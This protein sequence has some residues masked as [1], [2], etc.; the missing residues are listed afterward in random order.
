MPTA[1]KY[2]DTP[3]STTPI[4]SS[5][6]YEY[7]VDTSRVV[8]PWRT[9]RT[10]PHTPP[11]L[12]ITRP[13]LRPALAPGYYFLS[14]AD[15]NKH[16]GTFATSGTGFI[17]DSNGDLIYAGLEDGMGFCSEWVAGMTD[18]RAQ[19][20]D[21]KRHITYWNGCNTRGHHWG[22][23]WG[24]V[25]FIDEEYRKFTLNPDLGIN[26]FEP[27]TRGNIDV[28][29]HEM[30]ERGTMLV[31]SYNNTQLDLRHIGGPEDAWVADSMFFEIDV[32]TQEVLFEWR[33]LGNLDFA[34]TH[35][36]FH[37]AGAGTTKKVPWDWVHIN[38]V[39]RVGEDYLISTRHHFAIYLISGK[40]GSVIWKLDGLDGGDF[41]SIPAQFRW[42]HHARAHN[43]TEHGM[44]VSV[45]N[46]MVNGP[47]N[48]DTQTTGL[49][50]WLPLPPNKN[51]PP[52][53][54]RNLRSPDEM[55]FT[56]TQG[57]YQ[58]DLGNGNGLIGY[59]TV[60]IIRE[61]D[62]SGSILWQAQ[63]GEMNAVM[64]YRGFKMEWTGTPRDWDPVVLIENPRLH[65]P[66]VYVSWNGA[67]GV[68]G[69]AVFAGKTSEEM[70]AVGA[71]EKRGFETVF[72]LEGKGVECVQLGAV[73]DGEIIRMSNIACLSDT[74]D[75]ITSDSASPANIH[76]TA[77]LQNE[78]SRL[79]AELAA[80][81]SET[82]TAYA[83][84]AK[85]ALGVVGLVFAAWGFVLLRDWRA[86]RRAAYAP[87]KREEW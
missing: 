22:H 11:V 10:S 52:V 49:A 16:D 24:R 35:Y 36:G 68:E 44:T 69:W 26:T 74:L 40:D 46:N 38:S 30:T 60:P 63:F 2:D 14:P 39:Q 75:P 64:N 43:V 62:S 15:S 81:Q 72:D 79:H 5:A 45:F 8:W 41:G 3:Y 65:T 83:L 37:A 77:A 7:T 66:R 54:V 58:M 55:L 78:I 87:V 47:H 34:A 27:A 73:R 4:P 32:R 20:L 84:F 85:V 80:A 42:Q 18:W 67:T 31:T 86:R 23:R 61:F 25:T 70:E 12:N 50:F 53:L 57:S 48:A 13:H 56:A 33:A 17:M 29:E 59:G 82:W 9:Y 6:H 76:S 21:G 28:H 1:A 19:M 71:A 51:N